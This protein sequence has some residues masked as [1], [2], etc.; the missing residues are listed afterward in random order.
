MLARLSDG[1]P[2]AEIP[3]E[4]AVSLQFASGRASFAMLNPAALPGL[5]PNW[6]SCPFAV[7]AWHKNLL[8]DTLHAASAA[9]DQ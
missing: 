2:R 8:K 1:T 7:M 5:V 3:A 6:N 9:I 4:Q